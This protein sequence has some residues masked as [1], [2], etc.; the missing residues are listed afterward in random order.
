MYTLYRIKFLTTI[1]CLIYCFEMSGQNPSVYIQTDRSY[2][3][4]GEPVLFKAFWSDGKYGNSVS[5]KD[6]LHLVVLDQEGLEVTSKVFPMNKTMIDGDLI[7]PDILTEGDYILIGFTG[8]MKNYLPDKIYSRILEIRK[9]TDD[10]LKTDIV[11]TADAYN[12]GSNLTAQ[13]RFSL[14]DSKPVPASFTYELDGKTDIFLD[15]NNMANNEGVASLRLQ[16]P[17][18]DNKEILKLI[19]VPSYKGF[20]NITGIIIPTHFNSAGNETNSNLSTS[21]GE[22]KHLNIE[23]KPVN[24]STGK[25]VKV[26]LEINVTDDSGLPATA[27]LSVS[28]SNIVPHQLANED[29]NLLNYKNKLN[30][31]PEAASTMDIKEYFVQLLIRDTQLPGHPFVIQE[32]NNPKKLRKNV[33]SARSSPNTLIWEP[34]VTTDK[35]GSAFVNFINTDK[36]AEVLISVDGMASNGACGSN[37]IHYTIKQ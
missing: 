30:I 26:Q 4:P 18:F 31:Q 6:S 7:L 37:S 21:T 36:S 5:P 19:I 34:N 28:V 17:K 1:I 13:I 12:S 9:S 25:N 33:F 8:S 14:N 29:D 24:T 22:S 20:R 16:L 2:Y 10:F 23:L 11:L 35:S 27:S 15:G 3:L 32:K